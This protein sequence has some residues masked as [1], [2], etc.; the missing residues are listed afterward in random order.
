MVADSTLMALAPRVL[1]GADYLGLSLTAR[2]GFLLSRI[3]GTTSAADLCHLLGDEPET[4]RDALFALER[5]G[6]IY[7]SGDPPPAPEPASGDPGIEDELDDVDFS[8][9]GIDREALRSILEL[10]QRL[11][12]SHWEALGVG[13]DATRSQIKKAF[14][15]ASKRFHPDR[16]FGR[17]LGS[18]KQRLERVFTGIKKAYDTLSHPRKRKAYAASH[19]PPGGPPK[20]APTATSDPASGAATPDPE[21]EKRLEERR[22]Q[23][24]EERKQRSGFSRGR[25]RRPTVDR[26]FYD[27]GVQQLR[28]GDAIGAEA[29]LKRALAQDPHNDELRALYL[30]A[31]R[32][33]AAFRAKWLSKPDRKS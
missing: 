31:S 6:V 7:W 9:L 21:L 4:L 13:G 28:D 19:P 24:I 30:S 2:D 15:A 17:D 33:A 5:L 12:T 22:R 8:T 25:T 1:E 20:S 10:E 18:Y 14:F 16:F 27:D 3:D 29:S 26:G 32:Q 23:I 11:R